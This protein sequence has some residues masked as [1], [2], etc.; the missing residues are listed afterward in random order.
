MNSVDQNKNDFENISEES[1][2]MFKQIL[3][4]M[5]DDT[6]AL[7]SLY[8]AYLQRGEM[9]NAFYYLCQWATH[10]ESTETEEARS[11]LQKMEQFS[12]QMDDEA[13]AISENLERIASSESNA[14]RAS[15]RGKE[16]KPQSAGSADL[17]AELSLAWRLFKADQL[18]QEEYSEVMND[19][20]EIS[21]HDANTLVSV[22]HILGQQSFKRVNRVINYLVEKSEVPF[23]NLMSIEIPE[24]VAAKLP[25]DFYSHR[26]ALP[27]GMVGET[28]QLAVLNPFNNSIVAEAERLSNCKCYT[29]LVTAQDYDESLQKCRS[30]LEETS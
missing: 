26:A 2:Q 4:A 1:M 14:T 23:V 18:T 13:R 20:T 17:D 22:L 8:Q 30:L 7:R 15:A 28:L 12:E 21:V 10:L 5:P 19:I 29:Y 27:F 3:E 16:S 6:L 24:N 9:E 11:L 25:I